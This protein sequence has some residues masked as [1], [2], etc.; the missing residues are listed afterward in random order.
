MV[1]ILQQIHIQLLYSGLFQ[2]QMYYLI[3]WVDWGH[4]HNTWEPEKNLC[5]EDL[6]QDYKTLMAKGQLRK[7]KLSD[8]KQEDLHSYKKP[9]IDEFFQKLMESKILDVISPLDIIKCYN[10]SKRKNSCNDMI[11]PYQPKL[12]IRKRKVSKKLLRQESL[13]ALKTWQVELN[14]IIKGYDPAPLFV[15][16]NV[17]LEGPP[18]DFIYINERKE[19]PGVVIPKDPL[20]GCDCEDCYE[21]RKGCCVVACGSVLA[22]YKSNGRLRVSRGTPIYECNIRCK[23]GPDCL[24]R[25]AQN[26]RKVKIC[27]FRTPNGR[28]W[29]VKTL[30]K[31]KKGVFI[32]EYVGEVRID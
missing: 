7:R 29:G 18:T 4:E 8:P 30:Q 16:N 15:E 22:Y 13:R 23:C 32:M 14:N 21:N 12:R 19:G 1:V 28:G 9:K 27:I 17:D 10:T 2:G 20:I 11:V 24:N 31:I 26:G 6:L 3:K 5:C 25:V